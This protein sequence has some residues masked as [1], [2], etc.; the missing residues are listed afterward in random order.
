MIFFGHMGLGD[1]LAA[2]LRRELPRPWLLMGTVA[3]DF[4]DKPLYVGLSLASGHRGM[5][6]VRG[7][8]AFGHTFLLAA[9]V[10][11]AG[12]ALKSA[13]LQ[14]LALGMAT[15]PIL[16]FL[17]DWTV[18]GLNGAWSGCAAFWPLTGWRFPLIVR[19]GFAEHV[20]GEFRWTLLAFELAGALWLWLVWR[21]ARRPA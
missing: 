2:P 11:G 7:T 14:A 13:K 17:S 3:P 21:R 16:D 20:G 4:L 19:P 5:G 9:L 15:H 12:R 18:S 6:I 1:A 10:W 8:R